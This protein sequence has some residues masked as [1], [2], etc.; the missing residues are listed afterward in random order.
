MEKD[1]GEKEQQLIE[2]CKKAPADYAKIKHLIDE[3]AD[4]N[5]VNEYGDSLLSSIIGYF[6][7]EEC[8]GCEQRNLPA[9]KRNCD[10][11][12]CAEQSRLLDI[13]ELFIE[14]GWDTVKYGLEC[15]RELT[16]V[17]HNRV[18]FDVAK[19]ILECPLSEDI[20][21]YEAALETIGTEES[22]QRCCEACPEEENLFYTI[23]ELI[24]AKMNKKDFEGIELF[25]DAIGLRVDK[26]IYF[27]GQND[28]KGSKRGWDFYSDIGFVCQDKV[29]V[30]SS[31]INILMMNDRKNELPQTEITEIFG[32]SFYNAVITDISFDTAS[33]RRKTTIYQ[34]QSII[35]DFDNGRQ[36]RF[37]H[38]AGQHP[39]KKTQS[40]FKIINKKAS[41][42]Q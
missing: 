13:V 36:L 27:S 28:I 8:Y 39:D 1:F 22:Y 42:S 18:I 32:K 2:E 4:I 14:N 11:C 20:Q 21:S 33:I 35:I 3:G 15:I 26:I 7:P 12:P 6:I 37:T 34:Q 17:P 10:G 16:F 31:Y 30:L 23:Y 19:R 29:L 9:E 24:D 40:S 41:V 25:Y 38:N 5:A